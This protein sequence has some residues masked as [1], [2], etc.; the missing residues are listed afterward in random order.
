MRKYVDF[1]KDSDKRGFRGFTP[2]IC[3]FL[4]NVWDD[5]EEAKVL[6]IGI[7]QN[8][9]RF[10]Y[11][12]TVWSKGLH[13]AYDVLDELGF[14]LRKECERYDNEGQG[15]ARGLGGIEEDEI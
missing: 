7:L 14:E 13:E 1:E 3:I 15:F 6:L 11:T 10:A 12:N 5:V 4:Q 2:E 9:P 8:L